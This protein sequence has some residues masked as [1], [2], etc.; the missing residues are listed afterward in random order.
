[1]Y[2]C[3]FTAI[4]AQHFIAYGFTI[5]SDIQL[6]WIGHTRGQFP[7]TGSDTSLVADHSFLKITANNNNQTVGSTNNPKDSSITPLLRVASVKPINIDLGL[8]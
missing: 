5:K 4:N 1:M 7:V 3:T 2:M 6:C 8:R